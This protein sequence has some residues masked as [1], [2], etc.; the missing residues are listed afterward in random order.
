MTNKDVIQAKAAFQSLPSVTIDKALIDR[1]L[2]GADNYVS[3]SLKQIELVTADLYV[4]ILTTP[5]FKEGSLAVTYDRNTLKD[6][7]V[8]IYTKYSDEKLS[9]LSN[10]QGGVE[11]VNLW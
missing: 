3:S 7:A 2:N 4:E 1:S 6:L 11:S 8:K 10:P 5:D 9:N